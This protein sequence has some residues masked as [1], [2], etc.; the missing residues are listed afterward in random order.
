[1]RRF[2]RFTVIA[3]LMFT[4]S[5]IAWAQR[6]ADL[7]PERRTPVRTLASR[8]PVQRSASRTLQGQAAKAP[9]GAPM[10]PEADKAQMFYGYMAHSSAW[11]KDN[12]GLYAFNPFIT[13]TTFTKLPDGPDGSVAADGGGCYYDGKYY[14]VTFAGFMGMIL[15]EY[16][17]Y[18]A[19]TWEMEKYIPVGGGSVAIDM[20][21][22]P[23]TGFIYGCFYNDAFDGLVFG[24][25][26]PETGVRTAICNLNRIFFGIS[27]NAKGEVY[28]IDE[29]GGLYKFNKLTGLRT[30]VGKTGVMQ[31]YLGSATFDQKTGDL[32]WNAVREDGSCL[33]KVDTKTAQ[34]T[35]VS[36]FPNLEEI[37]GMFIP[38][39]AA[40]DLAPAVAENLSANFEGPALIGSFSFTLPVTTYDGTALQGEMDYEIAVNDVLYKSGK[41]MAGATISETVKV[42]TA[43]MYKLSVRPGNSYGP[44]PT[45]F[46]TL[47]I[48]RDLPT[49]VSD[50]KAVEGSKPNEVILTWTAPEGSQHGGYLDTGNLSYNIQRYHDG[51]LTKQ[52]ST[53]ALTYTDIITDA[54]TMSPYYYIVTPVVSGVGEG[55][56]ARSNSIGIGS[57]L[58][59]PY[60]QSF[61]AEDCLDIITIIDRHG[62]GKTWEWDP[63]FTAARAQYDW[64][65]AKNEWLITPAL[66]LTAGY[67]YKVGFDVWGRSGFTERFEVKMGHGRKHTD[68][69]AAVYPRTEVRNDTPAHHS[70]LAKVSE[71]GDYNFGFH[72]LSDVDQW[73]LYLDNISIEQGP[74][75]GT[76]GSVGNM[77]VK[78]G[79]MGALKADL[80]FTAPT[81]DVENQPLSGLDGIKVYRG[82]KLIATLTATAGER[83]TYSDLEA[84]QG[85]NRYRI[86]PF[87]GNGDGMDITESIYVGVD[88]PKAPEN[89]QLRK[90]DGKPF[91]SWEAPSAGING[92]YV[93]PS[94]VF[95]Y[96]I[97]SD[98]AEIAER[99]NGTSVMDNT[100]T[101]ADGGQAFVSYAVFAQNI[102]GYSEDEV[103]LTNEVCFGEPFGLP[104][105]ESFSGVGVDQGPWT[106]DIVNGDPWA[107][108][109]G[110]GLYPDTDA[111]DGDGGLVSFQ[112]EFE[113]DELILYSSN[114]SLVDAQKPQLSFWYYNNPG[115]FDKLTAMIRLNDDPERM[116]TLSSINMDNDCG[117]EGWKNVTV[118]LSAYVGERIQLAFRF[119]SK[120]DF[121][122]HLDNI[123]ISGLRSDLPYVTDLTGA[124]EG[125]TLSLA[126]SEPQDEQGL[127]FIGYNV[128]RDGILLN[129]DEPLIDPMYDDELT[130]SYYHLYE[131][132]VVYEEGETIFSNAVDQDGNATGIGSPLSQPLP[133]GGEVIYDLA[134]QRLGRV[135]QHG[136]YILSGRKTFRK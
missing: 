109:N 62:D 14:A 11:T 103:A 130:D 115:S 86:V 16:S 72:A 95:Y 18:N 61:D 75:L 108:I 4:I 20:D 132:T 1:M 7:A 125:S 44:A 91:I 34:L 133:R 35:E 106:F 47:W 19:E 89:V 63:T 9:A 74:R 113:D 126:W 41:G 100:L 45:K 24:R 23:T 119:L 121:Y 25:M 10:R 77:T 65:N 52:F 70:T 99:Y 43:G 82:S 117:E 28:G 67:V 58:S 90:V 136:T 123:S 31:Q 98:N 129:T 87:N 55:E 105:H 101:L 39:P 102:A 71:D 128:Y 81:A 36:R 50:L 15:A 112:P 32:Y 26:N 64:N 127:G 54:G 56:A 33:Y 120:S 84:V 85:M 21:F 110:T 79:E 5:G 22:D 83:I 12:F 40:E 124:R 66:H 135:P 78:A 88:I 59:L 3:T 6:I 57:A 114:V 27:V 68:M 96:V 111:Q 122:M 73:W 76:P 46:V 69:T 118:D 107:K 42:S 104:F 17:V 53:S 48:G 60:Y 49:A 134:G 97:R 30:L 80:A 13:P 8:L 37:Q 29:E 92:G 116:V 38:V 51:K 2:V 131:V 94:G 93:D